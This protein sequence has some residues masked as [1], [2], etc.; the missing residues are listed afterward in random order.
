MNLPQTYCIWWYENLAT[1][2]GHIVFRLNALT[3]NILFWRLLRL[4]LYGDG[5]QH[6]VG[7]GARRLRELHV[8]VLLELLGHLVVAG[9]RQ[10]ADELVVGVGTLAVLGQSGDAP[11]DGLVL[12]L[13]LGL[14]GGGL[15]QLLGL[16]LQSAEYALKTLNLKV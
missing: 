14:P 13:V 1:Y 10:L 2:D 3:L 7:G 4:R 16:A 8:K 6:G 15:H 9:E 12:V 5:P 11:H